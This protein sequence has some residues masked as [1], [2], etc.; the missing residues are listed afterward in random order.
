MV[1]LA[2][3]PLL[4]TDL[5]WQGPHVVLQS[6]GAQHLCCTLGAGVVQLFLAAQVVF[7]T[8]PE[9]HGEEGSL[10]EVCH[11]ERQNE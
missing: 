1:C 9:G 5:H 2:P 11:R 8:D 6:P 7:D 3:A 4:P 10:S